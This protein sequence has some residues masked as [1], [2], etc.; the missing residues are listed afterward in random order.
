MKLERARKRLFDRNVLIGGRRRR[1]AAKTLAAAPGTAEMRGLLTALARGYLKPAEFLAALRQASPDLAGEKRQAVWEAYAAAPHPALAAVLVELG[2]PRGLAVPFEAGRNVLAAA[3]EGAPA[4]M[5]RAAAVLAVVVPPADEGLNDAMAA[6]WS[7]SGFDELSPIVLDERRQYGIAG[8]TMLARALGRTESGDEPLARLLRRLDGA[9]DGAKVEALWQCLA[10]VRQPALG[11]VLAELGWP[12]DR[13]VPASVALGVLNLAV[14]DVDRD[15][16]A[17]VAVLARA[18]PV[19]DEAINDAIYGAWV[20]A[21]SRALE[22]VLIEQDRQPSKPALEALLALVAGRL[23]RYAALEDADGGLLGE[24]FALAPE[25]YRNRLARTVADA[26]DRTIKLAYRRALQAGGVAAAQAAE[27]LTLVGDEDG[28]FEQI[29]ELKLI[30]VLALCERWANNSARPSQPR[31][32]AAVDEA[33]GVYLELGELASESAPELP[34][35]MV[36]L[37]DYWRAEAPADE[38]LQ[39]DLAEEDPFYTARALYLGAERGLVDRDR[40]ARARKSPHWPVRLVG[41]LLD[42]ASM[43]EAKEDH[44]QWVNASADAAPLLTATVGGSPEDYDRRLAEIE[45]ASGPTT[46]RTRALLRILCIFQGVFVAGGITVSDTAAAV[47]SR[48]VEV[49]DAGDVKP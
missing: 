48:A 4:P 36:D 41:R 42:P 46:A 37:F 23:E 8:V 7:R 19:D 38:V 43:T 13:P 21:Q 49:E 12:D 29:P 25:A 34:A 9:E 14:A 28:L 2:W 1:A 32:R 40:M 17:A 6:A 16:L 35:G 31:Y 15:I 10:V 22:A 47:D 27:S 20:R 33:V 18:L 45:Q 30:Q 11:A 5:L 39:D 24:A 44:V 26:H 3:T